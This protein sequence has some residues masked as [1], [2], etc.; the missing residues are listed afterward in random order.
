[1]LA[2]AAPYLAVIDGD[3]QHDETRLP[4]MLRALKA[5]ELDLVVG[6]RYVAGGSLGDWNER[7]QSMS[8]FATRLAR[9]LTHA[10]L[11]DPMSG[12]FL[13]RAEILVDCVYDL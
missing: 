4:L 12:F 2:T 5:E 3:L 13:V 10:D 11:H 6:S 8:R 1:M 7:R 9:R